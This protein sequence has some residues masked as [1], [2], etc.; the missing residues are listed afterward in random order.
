MVCDGALVNKI[1]CANKL[2]DILN[3]EGHQNIISWSKI[4]VLLLN[5]WI[6]PIGGGKGVSAVCAVSLFQH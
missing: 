5:W 2:F 1:D 4:T 3:L 6:L